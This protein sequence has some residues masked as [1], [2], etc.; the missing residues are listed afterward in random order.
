MPLSNDGFA[1]SKSMT[2]MSP[3][4]RERE[5]EG[6]NSGHAADGQPQAPAAHVASVSCSVQSGR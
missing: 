2:R 6:A 5:F 4:G 1:V 3:M